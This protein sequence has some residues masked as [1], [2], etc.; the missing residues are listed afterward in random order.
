MFL[1]RRLLGH[2]VCPGRC[3][4]ESIYLGFY[5]WIPGWLAATAQAARCWFDFAGCCP[6]LASRTRLLFS[7]PMVL[8]ALVPP[9]LFFQPLVFPALV[10]RALGL[11]VF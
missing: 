5:G 2:S 7:A 11:R 10:L 1:E 4:R 3:H 8:P 9:A 6:P